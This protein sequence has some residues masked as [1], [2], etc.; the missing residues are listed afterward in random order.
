MT[1]SGTPLSETGLM[2]CPDLWFKDC[3]LIIH[4]GNVLFHDVETIDGCL[5]TTLNEMAFGREIE[6]AYLCLLPGD[7]THP[8]QGRWCCELETSQTSSISSGILMRVFSVEGSKQTCC[9]KQESSLAQWR[10]DGDWLGNIGKSLHHTGC[11]PG[12]IRYIRLMSKLMNEVN[13]T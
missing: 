5:V 7:Q 1:E 10:I 11:G 3:G 8:Y 2:C 12:S 9:G 4:T 13:N 6:G